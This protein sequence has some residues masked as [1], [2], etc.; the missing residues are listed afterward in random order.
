[1]V[2]TKKSRGTLFWNCKDPDSALCALHI[3]RD[4][5]GEM[6]LH[7]VCGIFA[8]ALYYEYGYQLMALRDRKDPLD[9]VHI[10]CEDNGHLIDV[11]GITDDKEAFT[12]EFSDV[13]DD[14]TVEEP[15][16]EAEVQSIIEE[17]PE[18]IYHWLMDE[19]Q[20]VIDEWRSGYATVFF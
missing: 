17:M 6:F 18:D 15:I 7:G 4:A 2:A 10:Y 14:E 19:A 12:A 13:I 11:R 8:L 3:G 20:K 1:M 16:D 9:I 5:T